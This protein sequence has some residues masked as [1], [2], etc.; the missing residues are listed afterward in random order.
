MSLTPRQVAIAAT[1]ETQMSGTGLGKSCLHLMAEASRQA[2]TS[3]GMPKDAIQGVMVSTTK[4]QHRFMFA[5]ALA[6]YLGLRPTT[7]LQ[8]VQGGTTPANSV[9]IAAAMIAA[10]LLDNVLIAYA[11]SQMSELDRDGVLARQAADGSPYEAPWGMLAATSY[12]MLAQRHMHEYGTTSEQMARFAV[13]C[14]NHAL[15]HP[16]AQMKAPITVSD[17]L[18]S[19]MISSPFHL[20]DICLIGDG[21]CAVVVSSA[22]TARR[23]NAQ[24][25]YLL[26]YGEHHHRGT[27]TRMG[28][29]ATT[30]GQ[31]ISGQS[32]FKMAGLTPKDIDIVQLYDDFTMMPMI[33]LE[34]LGF[35]EKGRCGPF[36]QDTDLSI[37]GDLPTNTFGGMLSHGNTVGFGHIVEAARQ[38]MGCAGPTQVPNADT[39]LVA[40][41]GGVSFS[42]NAT[43]VLGR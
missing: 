10:G 32:A 33:M 37:H 29:D 13:V 24:P 19:R 11:S 12:G 27:V 41:L 17:V 8:L 35:C 6:S 9:G 22:E 43:M 16:N 15:L 21:G 23:Y 34:D 4:A 40:A 18:T 36:V 14:R 31:E 20:L 25:A 39:A 30:S 26:G 1:G 2:L 7:A 28:G 42:S 3:I 5:E 38:V